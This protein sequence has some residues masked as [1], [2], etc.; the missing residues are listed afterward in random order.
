M[1]T[2]LSGSLEL[3]QQLLKY[4]QPGRAPSAKD[5]SLYQQINAQLATT[6]PHQLI[7]SFS[8]LQVWVGR[9]EL[10]PEEMKEEEVAGS[11][12]WEKLLMIQNAP[13]E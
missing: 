11:W 1:T 8:L 10:P 13:S 4:I 3:P 12:L 6:H 2:R 5:T 9:R 7:E